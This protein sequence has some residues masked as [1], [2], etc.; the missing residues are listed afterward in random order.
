MRIESEQPSRVAITV[1]CMDDVK[2]D[3]AFSLAA[4]I[5]HAHA[6]QIPGLEALGILNWRTTVLPDSRNIIAQK[7]VEEGFTHL[8][9]IDS[10]MKFPHDML[11]RLLRHRVDFVG[12]NASMRNPP[13]KT[14]AMRV[15]GENL[16]TNSHS[17]GLEKVERVG[18]GVV[19]HTV[20]VLHRIRKRPWFTFEYMPS[21]H[22]HRGEDYVFC[23]KVRKAGFEIWVDHDV[24]KEVGHVGQ[25]AFYPVRDEPQEDEQS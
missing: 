9:W 23:Q 15:K 20:D 10:D 24:S 1:P 14:T 25:H 19:L 21:K 5:N 7:A 2:S 6:D 17:S 12:I 4:M 11:G 13:F 16:I 22:V 3:F 8:L 18:L